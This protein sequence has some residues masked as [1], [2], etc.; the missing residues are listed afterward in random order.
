MKVKS[1]FFRTF[2]FYSKVFSKLKRTLFQVR[3]YLVLVMSFIIISVRMRKRPNASIHR[4]IYN[5]F[6][7]R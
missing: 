3:E 6:E 2:S 1:S 4:H 5:L 7:F